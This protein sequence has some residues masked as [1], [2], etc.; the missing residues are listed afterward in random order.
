ML[1]TQPQLLIHSLSHLSGCPNNGVHR[2][3][4]PLDRLGIDVINALESFTLILSCGNRHVETA[5]GANVLGN[6]LS[7]ITHLISILAKQPDCKPLQ[8][9]EIVTTGTITAAQLVHAGETWRTDLQGI[10]LPGLSIEFSA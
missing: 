5:R 9:G 7:A 6:P 2:A 4:Q 1:L 3:P 8:T 10:S